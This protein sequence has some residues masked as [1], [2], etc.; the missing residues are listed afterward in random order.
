MGTDSKISWCD[1]TWNPWQGCTKVSDGCKF[2]YMY[3]EK[4][5]YGQKADVV[6]RSKPPTFRLPL[7]NNPQGQPKWQPGEF[8]FVCSWSDFCIK[9]ADAWR[10]DAWD[11][12]R[13]RKDLVFLIPT[14][15]PERWAQCVP[16]DWATPWPNVV[17]GASVE[18][19]KTGNERIHHLLRAKAAKRFISYE[20]ALGPLDLYEAGV[21]LDGK[22]N[23]ATGERA[24]LDWVVCGGESGGHEARMSH[25]NWF[26]NVRDQCAEAGIAFHFKQW[27]EWGH[28]KA[29]GAR[30][31]KWFSMISNEGKNLCW[32]GKVNNGEQAYQLDG[33]DYAA[34][35]AFMGR[36]KTGRLLDGIEHNARPVVK[37]G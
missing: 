1:H 2:C 14:K 36:E 17:L 9:E 34:S 32:G 22:L 8:V 33:N 4:K 25:P 13:Q 31:A 15:R 21:K 28:I 20:P 29:P 35:M 27:G 10:D 24:F 18:D 3:R 7:K 37:H 16:E 6:V 11:I 23:F 5:Q 30:H 26:R 12:M 19:Q